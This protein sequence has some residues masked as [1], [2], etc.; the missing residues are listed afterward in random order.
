MLP[1]SGALYSL[2]TVGTAPNES[3]QLASI[4][5]QTGVLTPVGTIASGQF[6]FI[7]ATALDSVGNHFFA[8]IS[9]GSTGQWQLY[10]VNTQTG[11]V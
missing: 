7:A 4:N 8:Y 11:S 1:S 10:A 9:V 2:D 5:A 6:T 3:L